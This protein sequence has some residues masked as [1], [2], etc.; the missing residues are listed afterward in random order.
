M[1][2]NDHISCFPSHTFF[3]RA[4]NSCNLK[5]IFSFFFFSVVFYIFQMKAHQLDGQRQS[6]KFLLERVE[7]L[8]RQIARLSGSPGTLAVGTD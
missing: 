1:C 5:F 7:E 3:F 4:Y 6:N 2:T 8:E